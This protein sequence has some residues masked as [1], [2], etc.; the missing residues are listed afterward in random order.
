MYDFIFLAQNKMF[1]IYIQSQILYM[2]NY[3]YFV[4]KR[5]ACFRSFFCIALEINRT[6]ENKKDFAHNNVITIK[7]E[8]WWY[9]YKL[10]GWNL[11]STSS[12]IP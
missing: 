12:A 7:I 4:S 9:M 8:C 3:R 6:L 11:Q 10:G 2:D 1:R 5:L